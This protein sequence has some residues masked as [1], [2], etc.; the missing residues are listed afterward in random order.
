MNIFIESFSRFAPE[1]VT[2][3]TILVFPCISYYNSH[4]SIAKDGIYHCTYSNHIQNLTFF[5]SMDSLVFPKN[6]Y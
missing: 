4:W 5:I 6:E 1:R 3:S 2:I